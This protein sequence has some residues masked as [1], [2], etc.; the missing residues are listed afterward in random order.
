MARLLQKYLPKYI[1]GNP[2]ILVENNPGA[3]SMI[4]AN[5]IYNIAK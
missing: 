5:Q 1:P 4:V 2:T 3:A